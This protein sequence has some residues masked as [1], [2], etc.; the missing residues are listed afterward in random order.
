MESLPAEGKKDFPNGAGRSYAPLPSGRHALPQEVVAEHQRARLEEAILELAGEVGYE[1]TAVKDVLE[2]AGTSRR[3]FYTHYSDKSACFLAAYNGAVERLERMVVAAAS[4]GDGRR[5]LLRAGLAALLSFTDEDPSVARAL[6]I[7]VHAAG[8]EALQAR[9]EAMASAARALDRLMAVEGEGRS[10]SAVTAEG[11]LGGIE[12]S[13]R[14]Q[15]RDEGRERALDLLGELMYF[16]VLS[17]MGPA[18]ASEMAA[19]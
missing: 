16:A 9:S 5:E 10:P 11:V 1:E 8:P 14:F 19:V 6:L 18:A 17:Y 4:S 15:L 7:E 13:L 12:Q 3:V 2:R